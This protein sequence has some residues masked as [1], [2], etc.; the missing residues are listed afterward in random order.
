MELSGR[1]LEKLL[2]IM[3]EYQAHPNENENKM[4]ILEC[5]ESLAQLVLLG[6]M[7]LELT[8]FANEIEQKDSTNIE[9][10]KSIMAGTLDLLCKYNSTYMDFN[11]LLSDCDKQKLIIIATSEYLKTWLRKD[12]HARQGITEFCLKRFSLEN[13]TLRE[14]KVPQDILKPYYRQTKFLDTQKKAIQTQALAEKIAS[15]EE[16]FTKAGTNKRYDFLDLWEME[17]RQSKDLYILDLL[18]V[19]KKPLKSTGD[20]ARKGGKHRALINAYENYF[21]LFGDLAPQKAK[22]MNDIEYVVS[23]MQLHEIECTYRLFLLTLIAKRAVKEKG[24]HIDAPIFL[25]LWGR[26][27]ENDMLYV[28]PPTKES[29]NLEFSSYDIWE[30]ER[31]ISCLYHPD[32]EYLRHH[33]LCMSLLRNMLIMSAKAR[34]FQSCLPWSKEDFHMARK[35]YEEEFRVFDIYTEMI[36][37]SGNLKFLEDTDEDTIFKYIYRIQED[38]LNIGESVAENLVTPKDLKREYLRE[39][40]KETRAKLRGS[41]QTN[42]ENKE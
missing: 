12:T 8:N 34:P 19:H 24:Y 15:R 18:L 17:K 21:W 26:S 35:F 13:G 9:K 6:D 7:T 3:K 5:R 2:Q 38:I 1:E 32:E 30:Y 10:I 39:K 28:S 23:C 41:N 27:L 37:K 16:Y 36:G 25:N 22:S 11:D 42:T 33:V 20:R 29:G 31:Q 40:T 4:R 14:E